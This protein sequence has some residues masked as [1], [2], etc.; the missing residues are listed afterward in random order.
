MADTC[1]VELTLSGKISDREALECI[2]MTVME[3]NQ[4]IN[5]NHLQYNERHIRE[6]MR[7][8]DIGG[9]FT[10]KFEDVDYGNLHEIEGMLKKH[11]IHF[12]KLHGAGSEYYEA[13][14]SYFPGDAN[15]HEFHCGD[16][17]VVLPINEISTILNK[18]G[19]GA[20]RERLEKAQKALGNGAP[21]FLELSDELKAELKVLPENPN[22]NC[23]EGWRCPECHN[24][25]PFKIQT[26]IQAEVLMTDGGSV[27]QNNSHTGWNDDDSARCID[28]GYEAEI[29]TFME[30]N[31]TNSECEPGD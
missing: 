31:Q 9:G 12:T 30:E 10:L 24:Y 23:L 20:L 11:G 17:G 28:C 14:H 25:G 8:N 2:V 29:Y 16:S 15:F 13:V 22:T 21:D 5:P 3:S 4:V 18:D 6:Y 7:D 27:E 26:T 1:S 19:I